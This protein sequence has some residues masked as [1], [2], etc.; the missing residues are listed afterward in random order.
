MFF[1]KNSKGFGDATGSSG[2]STGMVDPPK[3]HKTIVGQAVFFAVLIG[4]RVLIAGAVLFPGK[5]P[6]II[7]MALCASFLMRC[8]CANI[9]E[10]K[11]MIASQFML[12]LICSDL[13][14]FLVW[15][16]VGKPQT[17]VLFL[18]WMAGT[19]A[20]VFLSA[21]MLYG[22]VNENIIVRH[23]LEISSAKLKRDYSIAVIS[24]IH[25]ATI[26]KKNVLEKAVQRI[27]DERPDVIMI[28]G[29]IAE[30]HTPGEM[31]PELF[32]ILGKFRSVYGTFFVHGNHDRQEKLHNEDRTYTD[33]EFNMLMKRAGIKC[34][35]D[36]QKELNSD[37][38]IIGREDFS[39]GNRKT[40]EE[41]FSDVPE[42]RFVI[43]IEHQPTDCEKIAETGAELCLAGHYHGA[44]NWTNNIVY[45]LSDIPYNGCYHFG[46]MLLYV[47]AGIAGSKYP[48]RTHSHNE[49]L[50]VHCKRSR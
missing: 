42:N 46:E 10:T 7:L 50:M 2:K 34:I 23:S 28:L 29:D 1:T 18:L 38:V 14:C 15:I 22:V 37:L 19:A 36:Q 6:L 32:G 17:G 47:N 20:V 8:L 27:N 25:Y 13:L 11:G 35:D 31:I 49:Y 39:F 41:L 44:Q 33:E 48:I 30:E 40:V 9:W 3:L 43:V 26:Q 24:D 5:T 4:I 16:C 12:S 21:L 45:S